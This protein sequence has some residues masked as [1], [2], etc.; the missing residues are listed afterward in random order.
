MLRQ[1]AKDFAPG[2][3]GAQD[4]FAGSGPLQSADAV[5]P[6]TLSIT[7]GD[8]RLRST[9]SEGKAISRARGGILGDP[10]IPTRCSR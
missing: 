4:E 8:I 3:V 10:L 6:R 7:F 9:Q 1:E 2:A 5:D